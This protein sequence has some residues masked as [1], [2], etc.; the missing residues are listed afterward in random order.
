MCKKSNLFSVFAVVCFLAMIPFLVSPQTSLA[1]NPKNDGIIPDRRIDDDTRLAPA[2]LPFGTR[3]QAVVNSPAGSDC[4]RVGYTGTIYCYD[5]SDPSL[6]YLVDWDQPCGFEQCQVCG[7]CATNG[8]WVGL[9]D[10]AVIG[11]SSSDTITGCLEINGAPV[12]GTVIM[13]QR[14][15]APVRDGLDPDGCFEFDVDPAKPFKML[16]SGQ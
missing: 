8:W 9:A 11:G 1:E 7:V 5:G 13:L 15:G 14:G 4:I 2:N 12:S 3:V 16:I 6:P 10:I